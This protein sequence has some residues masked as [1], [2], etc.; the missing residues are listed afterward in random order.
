MKPRIGMGR[1]APLNYSPGEAAERLG[2]SVRKFYDLIA[3]GEI[4]TFKI[5]KRRLTSDEDL[6][7]FN[8]RQQAKG[9]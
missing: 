4:R 7:A 1:P 2:I 3:Q 6:T 9:E 5:G 8:R